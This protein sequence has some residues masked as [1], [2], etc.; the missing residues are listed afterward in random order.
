[1]TGRPYANI[2]K[3]SGP[4]KCMLHVVSSYWV[5]YNMTHETY[6]KPIQ[7]HHSH[8]LQATWTSIITKQFISC[9]PFWEG[10]T[11]S[12]LNKFLRQ[13]CSK[14]QLTAPCPNHSNP[15]PCR[16]PTV[17]SIWTYLPPYAY[18]SEIFCYD[19][20]SKINFLC[21]D[22]VIRVFHISRLTHPSQAWIK[23]PCNKMA[24]WISLSQ[25]MDGPG[26]DSRW[27]RET[28]HLSRPALGLT[29]PHIQSGVM[30]PGCDVSHQLPSSAE[31]K[32]SVELH[33]H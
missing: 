22:S 16:K 4:D 1:M 5:T 7:L 14:H 30:L 28:P 25:N 13:L 6:L 27:G 9:S 32:E 33:L 8:L 3:M 15:F 23:V 12:L 29:Q 18:E 19:F 20:S 31:V 26:I 10:S 17:R 11:A 2:C 21:F 24:K